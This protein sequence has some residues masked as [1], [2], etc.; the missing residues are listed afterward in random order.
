M[1]Q[2]VKLVKFK[3]ITN[4]YKRH[5]LPKGEDGAALWSA[6]NVDIDLTGRLARRDG[7][8]IDTALTSGDSLWS[9]GQN[10]Y[11]RDNGQLYRDRVSLTTVSGRVSYD[12]F[13]GGGVI[14]TDATDL[15]FISA[16]GGV[17]YLAPGTP[18]APT[19]AS[20]TGTLQ[21]ATYLIALTSKDADGVESA[22]SAF[23]DIALG[24][25]GGVTVTLP[26]LPQG[27]TAFNIY[28]TGPNGEVPTLHGSASGATYT[29]DD[30]ADGRAL[31][32]RDL[33]RMP[34]GSIAR[35]F[36]GRLLVATGSALFSSE[37]YNFGLY[38]PE[39]GFLL[40][41]GTVTIVV[42]MQNGVFVAADKTY[43]LAGTDV[44]TSEFFERLPYG[45]IP[46]TDARH[47]ATETAYW[48]SVKGLVAA[49]VDGS[50][51]NLQEPMLA[52]TSAATWGATIVL[53]D[54]D[55]I[56]STDNG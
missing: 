47:P 23:E 48:K 42:P 30:Y 27:A 29:I 11:Y 34:A 16:A 22:A 43:W 31:S 54:D 53:A 51:N 10:L 50:V 18:S 44:R 35:V 55:K 28:V 40:F 37:A 8:T 32:T 49:N 12:A 3:G 33:A 38:N 14:Y 20:T 41:P 26:A 24:S 9:D 45:A 17:S 5:A 7:F 13:P 36:N 46:G 52:I 2:P 15:K 6:E 21:P 39:D 25:T 56:V 4:R 19:L 1:A